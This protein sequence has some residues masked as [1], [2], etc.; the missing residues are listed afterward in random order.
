MIATSAV[1]SPWRGAGG[2][3]AGL[4][5]SAHTEVLSSR[6][7][8]VVRVKRARSRRGSYSIHALSGMLGARVS[9]RRIKLCL[10]DLYHQDVVEMIE[11]E[12]RQ[13]SFWEILDPSDPSFETAYAT[14]WDAFGPQGEM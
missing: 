11:R 2:S 8:V 13:F 10:K 12:T 7:R 4:A 1:T 9:S 5:T 6:S 3:P 14:L